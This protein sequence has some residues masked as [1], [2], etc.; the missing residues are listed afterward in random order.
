MNFFNL[1][2]LIVVLAFTWSLIAP[3]C[4]GETTPLSKKSVS[5]ARI[6]MLETALDSFKLDNKTYPSTQEGLKALIKNS[7]KEKYPKCN[8]PYL[9][10]Y[11]KDSWDSEFIYTQEGE[12]FK[13]ISY[14][15]DKKEGGKG[16]NEDIVSLNKGI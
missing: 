15:A 13:I 7:N 14:G 11:L 8:T 5:I 2:I 9:A 1:F 10:K 4:I 3:T 12:G 6:S 16:E